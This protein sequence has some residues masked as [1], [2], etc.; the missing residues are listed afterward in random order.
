MVI[1]RTECR[2]FGQSADALNTSELI[3]NA[4]EREVQLKDIK[5]TYLKMQ[6]Y[7]VFKYVTRNSTPL[8]RAEN[9]EVELL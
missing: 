7:S 8:C 9:G 2:I 6:I 3:Q 1:Q 4:P 5:I